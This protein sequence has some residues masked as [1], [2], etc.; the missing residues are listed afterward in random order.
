[1]EFRFEGVRQ[2]SLVHLVRAIPVDFQLREPTIHPRLHHLHRVRSNPVWLQ[3]LELAPV[4]YVSTAWD[5][6]KMSLETPRRVGVLAW[7]EACGVALV[8]PLRRP[9]A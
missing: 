8:A 9:G 5:S 2:E 3:A 4:L 6:A 7:E 1:M